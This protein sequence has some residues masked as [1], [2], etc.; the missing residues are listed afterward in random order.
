[1]PA[2][3]LS[4]TLAKLNLKIVQNIGSVKLVSFTVSTATCT[5][6]RNNN[7]YINLCF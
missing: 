3:I 2:E 7:S 1:M 4:E 5:S 6:C